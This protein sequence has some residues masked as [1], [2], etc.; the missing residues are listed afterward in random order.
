MTPLRPMDPWTPSAS[1][2]RR[3]HHD[4][5]PRPRQPLLGTPLGSVASDGRAL[6]LHLT[7]QD[8]HPTTITIRASEAGRDSNFFRVAVATSEPRVLDAESRFD[9][10]KEVLPLLI[11]AARKAD[12]A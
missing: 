3:P 5:D 10:R 12:A 2:P 11:T 7:Q 6:T 9:W 1:T 4:H 8:G